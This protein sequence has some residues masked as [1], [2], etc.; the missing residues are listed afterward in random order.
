MKNTAY[1]RPPDKIPFY[2]KLG[3]MVS[4]KV[5]KKDLLV[6]KL[7]AWY[8]KVAISSGVMESLV[9]HGKKDLSPRI[10]QLVRM[11]ASILPACPFCIDMNSFEYDRKN[12]SEEEISALAG[13][14]PLEEVTTFTRP[15]RLAVA[16]TKLISETPV[17]VQESFM[18]EIKSAF[19]ERE[20][21]I[22]AS[23]AAQVNY[24]ARLISA[25]GVPPAG[26]TD[27]CDF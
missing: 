21:V 13:R 2:I 6:P 11:Q 12:I 27:R 5:T 16:Y 15:E 24:W 1:I 14:I 9:A 26:F 10:L 4:K 23:T 3:L 20:I 19:T 18:E 22:L 25:L 7:L 17:M 8:P